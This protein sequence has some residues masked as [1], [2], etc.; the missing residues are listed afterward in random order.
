MATPETRSIAFDLTDDEKIERGLRLAA[1]LEARGA[2]DIE[3][4][5]AN[6]VFKQRA[7]DLDE[8]VNNLRRVVAS[9]RE[10]R[11][12]A[13]R[14]VPDL[15]AS[16][17]NAVTLTTGEIIDSRPMEQHERQ[18]GMFNDADFSGGDDP[19]GGDEAEGEGDEAADDERDGELEGDE[20]GEGETAD[21]AADAAEAAAADAEPAPAAGEAEPGDGAGTTIADLGKARRRRTGTTE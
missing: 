4:A 6:K 20:T 11:E 8:E 3:K 10:Y 14:W 15:I 21:E 13:I 18:Q 17:M 16:K 1:K 7:D 5:K 9:G 2:V 12:V 19:D